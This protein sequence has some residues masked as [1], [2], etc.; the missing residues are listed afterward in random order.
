MKKLYFA[1]VF[2]ITLLS[3]VFGQERPLA[4]PGER[5]L[6]KIRQLSF[7]GGNAEAYF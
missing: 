1:I 6:K 5:P 3:T 4:A 2:I 7:G